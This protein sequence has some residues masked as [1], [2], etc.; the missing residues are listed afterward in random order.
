MGQTGG[1]RYGQPGLV[2]RATSAHFTALCSRP[3]I[4][5][6]SLDGLGGGAAHCV[7]AVGAVVLLVVQEPAGI[8]Q[9]SHLHASVAQA[10]QQLC[11]AVHVEKDA[12]A[13][14]ATRGNTTRCFCTTQRETEKRKSNQ[15]LNAPQQ[16]RAGTYLLPASRRTLALSRPLF[17]RS[18]TTSCIISEPMKA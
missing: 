11:H 2:H 16:A 10:L 7:H 13:A 15:A 6:A 18:F 14:G 3:S 9:A 8:R 1:D 17:S 12:R 5:D 4:L